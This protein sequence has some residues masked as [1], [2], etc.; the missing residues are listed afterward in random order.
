MLFIIVLKRWSVLCESGGQ[1]DEGW[2]EFGDK[3]F[4]YHNDMVGANFH[5]AM[6]V[7]EH[8]Y[9]ATLVTIHSAQEFDFIYKMVFEEKHAKHPVWIGLI[10]VSNESFVWF[11]RSPLNYTNW[12]PNQPYNLLSK[13]YCTVLNSVAAVRGKWYDVGCTITYLV[14]C[15]KYLHHNTDNEGINQT[16]NGI[17]IADQINMVLGDVES[18]NNRFIYQ[19]FNALAFKTNAFIILNVIL[20]TILFVIFVLFIVKYNYR[21]LFIRRKHQTNDNFSLFANNS[22]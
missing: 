15:Q 9:G 10:R 14:L 4:K 3:C 17:S 20:I 22:D 19:Q 1:C 8:F 12:G 5:D 6:T 16:S 2:D 13:C 18:A 11:D 7:C 21:S